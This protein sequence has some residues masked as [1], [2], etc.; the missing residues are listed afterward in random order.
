LCKFKKQAW[1]LGYVLAKPTGKP[2]LALLNTVVDA[3]WARDVKAKRRH[4][5]AIIEAA[6]LALTYSAILKR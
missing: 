5:M 4:S 2:K 1:P 6:A 3:I